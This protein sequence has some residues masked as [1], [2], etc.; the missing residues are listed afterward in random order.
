MLLGDDHLGGSAFLIFPRA[1]VRRIMRWFAPP[2]SFAPI[3][4]RERNREIPRT[5]HPDFALSKIAQHIRQGMV[6]RT[7]AAISMLGGATGCAIANPLLSAPHRALIARGVTTQM[8]SKSRPDC[9]S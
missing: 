2:P 1:R 4:N 3:V 8:G 7:D 9:S 5:A 6:A